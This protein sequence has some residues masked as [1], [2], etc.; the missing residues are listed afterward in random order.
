MPSEP[1]ILDTARPAPPADAGPPPDAAP[2]AE[3]GPPPRRV[4]RRLIP[5]LAAAW[6]VPAAAAALHA[7]DLL[8]LLVLLITAGLLRSGRTLF[9]RLIL[10]VTLLLGVTA[11]AGL[12]FTVWPWGLHP[13]PVTGLAL[14]VLA[15]TA[16]A[17]GRRPTLPRP[18]W[19]DAV[20]LALATVILRY[21]ATPY[22][23]SADPVQ[24]LAALLLGEDN[25]R[26]LALVDVIGRLGGYPFL[27]ASAAREHLLSQLI[28]YPQGWHLSVALLDGFVV[29]PGTGPGGLAAANQ[30]IGWTFATFGLLTLALYWAAQWLPGRL[31]PLHR[32]LLAVLVG[33]LLLGTQ[34]P[35]LLS[36]G[37]STEALGMALTVV[38]AGL[39]A[40]PVNRRRE[41]LVLLGALLVGIA[42]S[43]YLFLLPAGLLVLGWLLIA[44]GRALRGLGRTTLVV[45]LA[46]AALVPIVPLAGLLLADQ[47]EAITAASGPDTTESRL[48][49][50]GLG[51][52]V[53]VALIL[54]G[55]RRTGRV[56][57]RYLP[58]AVT[59]VA[60]ALG[61]GGL[62]IA[63]GGEP[64]YYFNKTVHLATALLIVGTAALVRLLPAPGRWRG[65]GALRL[66]RYAARGVLATALAVLTAFAGLNATGLVDRDRSLLLADDISWAERFV[67]P[68]LTD[69]IWIARTCVEADRRYPPVPGT[70]TVVVSK[71]AIRSYRTS[72][73]LST[74][75]GTTA[76][77]ETG[78]YGLA[79]LEP[80]RTS[81]LLHRI[82]GPVR[83]VVVD[84]LA[85]RRIERIFRQ[86]PQL[87][88][89]V[90][91]VAA[92]VVD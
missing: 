24:H 27:D 54:A 56:W 92:V 49:L 43:Y 25:M 75:Q 64:G 39:V 2:P 47:A 7:T 87:R 20:P 44:R 42:F 10:A 83:L 88:A 72:L 35:R 81:E 9:D 66:L 1:T 52:V 74:L 68:D 6:L 3:P 45:A 63:E 65:G 34:L 58:V 22:L 5:A 86:E 69:R 11:A 19:A 32:L 26:H 77:T 51:G 59:V 36:S 48:A 12:L 28:Y 50:T 17:T 82:P 14:T 89:R 38:L 71:S 70:V 18:T 33:S 76:Q 21:L 61:V 67:H 40:R 73:C 31:H 78:I 41:Q 29:P 8:P 57:R 4:H 85:G 37:F 84:P 90:T 62:S 60:Y 13:V 30:Y 23:Q 15:F 80:D 46:T 55:I 16:A 79:F 91:T 53:G